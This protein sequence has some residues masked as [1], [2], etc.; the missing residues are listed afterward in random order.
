MYDCFEIWW[1]HAMFKIQR[2][3]LNIYNWQQYCSEKVIQQATQILLQNDDYTCAKMR[4][5][6]D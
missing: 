3:V 1:D 4:L 2:I 6:L 5:H